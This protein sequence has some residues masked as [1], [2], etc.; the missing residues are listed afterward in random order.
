MKYGDNYACIDWSAKALPPRRRT[1]PVPS[2]RSSLAMPRIIGDY[3]A[4]DCPIT[5]DRIDGRVAH[6][7]NLKRHDC[8][9]LETGEKED[10]AKT[11]RQN[12]RNEDARRDAAIDGI[13]ETVANEYFK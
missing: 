12:V 4:Y 9:L 11:H 8:R 3:A 2:A 13:V 1:E 6:A 10:N 7:E 5:G